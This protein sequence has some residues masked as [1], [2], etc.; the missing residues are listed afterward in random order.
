MSLK[1]H[2]KTLSQCEPTT[3]TATTTTGNEL[4]D[5][6]FGANGINTGAKGDL[7]SDTTSLLNAQGRE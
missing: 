3:T 4:K 1:W 5:A 7:F 2:N 6:L